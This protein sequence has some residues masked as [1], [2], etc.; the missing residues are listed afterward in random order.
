VSQK[1]FQQACEALWGPQY[2][3]PAARELGMHLRTLMRYDA[4]ERTVPPA[5]F[6][7]LAK[8]LIQHRVQIETLVP[9]VQA[10]AIM[11]N[12]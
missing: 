7:R 3:S 10:A 8:L 5:V 12:A 1:I 6:A 11:E 2:R 4:G 9:K